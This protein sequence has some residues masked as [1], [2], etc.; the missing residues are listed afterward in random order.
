MPPPPLA[1]LPALERIRA[2]TKA[3]RLEWQVTRPSRPRT[4]PVENY[5]SEAI[6]EAE[7]ARLFR[8][9]PPDRRAMAASSPPGRC[10]PTTTTALPLSSTRD[11]DG[12]FRAFLNVCRHRG[13]RLVA[14]TGRG[15]AAR[16]RRSPV[17]RL[18][19]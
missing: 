1:P 14:A 19:Y 13:M 15:R 18:T 6:R 4:S 2:Q 16:Q 5:T 12:R 17:P 10:S 11:A 8:P 3:G 9:L 7:I